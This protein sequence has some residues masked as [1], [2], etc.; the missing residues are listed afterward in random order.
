VRVAEGSLPGRV[1]ADLLQDALINVVQNAGQATAP[2]GR[3]SIELYETPTEE[4]APVRISVRDNGIGMDE[5]TLAQIYDPF[6]TTKET[7]TGLGL[8]MVRGIV[9]VHGGSLEVESALG[10]GT[11]VTFLLP[12]RVA[13]DEDVEGARDSVSAAV[14]EDAGVGSGRVL[15]A[16]DDPR[17]RT[18]AERALRRLGYEVTTA[19]NGRVA[20]ELLT[21]APEG[22]DLVLS[23][24][25]MPELGGLEL[26]EEVQQRGWT[27]PFL[28]MSGHGPEAV[29]SAE[30]ADEAFTFLEKPWTMD[31]LR[32]TMRRAM[33]ERAGAS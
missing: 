2:G 5:G 27:I 21:D 4:G 10:K 13:G 9:E 20:L 29:A 22:W 16:E 11:S 12:V 30:G 33:G 6:F 3:V 32:T 23:D 26:Y 14:P 8:P 24:L 7:G 31:T 15:L 17:L 28:F 18:A 1:D 25:V 19:E